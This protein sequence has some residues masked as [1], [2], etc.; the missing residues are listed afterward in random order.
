LSLPPDA[1]A[2]PPAPPSGPPGGRVFNLEGRPVPSVYLAA[3]LFAGG[4]LA[5]LFLTT[6]MAPG[7]ARSIAILLALVAL[8]LGL[9]AGAGYQA[10]ARLARD[11]ARYRGPSP[12]LA[13]PLVVALSALVSVLLGIVGVE[14]GGTP[15]G[16]LLGLLIVGGGYLAVTA[17]FVVRTGALTW[18]EMGFPAAGPARARRALRSFGTGI[19]VALPASVG[20]LYLTA[21]V[22]SL[23]EVR[24]PQVLAPATT[25]LDRLILALAVVVVAPIGEEIFF[26]GFALSAWVRDLPER[27]A[28]LRSAFF[29]AIVHVAN[30][31]SVSFLVGAG[32]A[33]LQMVVLVPLSVVLGLLLLRRGLLASIG[34]HMTYN[35]IVLVLGFAAGAATTS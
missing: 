19:L 33:L 30:I 3:W 26:R 25:E 11:P 28:I 20:I 32:Q 29:F 7:A 2:P 31:G 6:Q 27:S 14:P 15:A 9:G 16:Q 8:T 18:Q 1:D 17:L 34:G 22:G 10:I 4:G 21:I 5:V 24:A 35:A 12:L 23:L 13:F